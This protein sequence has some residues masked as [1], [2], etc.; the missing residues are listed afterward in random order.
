MRFHRDVRLAVMGLLCLFSSLSAAN[1]VELSGSV[2]DFWG[3]ALVDAQVSLVGEGSGAVTNS[4]G[5]WSMGSSASSVAPRGAKTLAPVVSRL[6]VDVGLVRLRYLG[7]DAFGRQNPTLWGAWPATASANAWNPAVRWVYD[8]A[9]TLIFSWYGRIRARLPVSSLTQGDLG[10]LI[11]DLTQPTNPVISD[12]GGIG[13]VTTYGGVGNATPSEGGA[14]N[15]GITGISYFAAIQVSQIP[16]DMKGQWNGGRACGQCAQVRGWTS[17][18][19]HSSAV[20]IDHK[21]PD[22]N[23]GIDLGGAPATDIMETL[24]GRYTGSWR[25]VSCD[26]LAGVSDGERALWVKEGSNSYWSLVQIRNPP[27]AVDAIRMRLPGDIWT[28]LAWATEAENFFKV[29]DVLL[30]D[31]NATLQVEIRYRMAKS[32]TLM[33]LADSLAHGGAQV[34]IP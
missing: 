20:R 11:I 9:D 6:A 18:G 23:C 16:D 21:C 3:H 30:R 22:S 34:L 12:T 25:F 31:T 14:C 27:S 28:D 32:D 17:T 15:Y 2:T 19:W 33:I 4:A 10:V 29:P 7:W 8:A 1:T 24:P 5:V 13:D 26:G